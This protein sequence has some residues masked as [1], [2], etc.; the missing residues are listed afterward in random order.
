MEERVGRREYE[1]VAVATEEL[2]DAMRAAIIEVCV[3]AH[4]EE[5]YRHLFEYI[6]ADG[7]HFLAFRDGELVSYAVVTTRWLQPAGLPVLRTAYVD[8]VSTLPAYQG[9]GFGSAVMR[10]LAANIDDYVI[11]CLETD[12]PAFYTRLGWEVWRGPLAGRTG[13]GLKPTPEQTGIMVLRQP[14]TPRLDLDSLLTIESQG[15]RIW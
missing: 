14:Q 1:V 4:E 2:D 8:A 13:H 3:A 11:A 5:D 9:Q 7:R 15:I 6:P 10:H 12:R